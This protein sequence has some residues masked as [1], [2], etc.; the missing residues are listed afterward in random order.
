MLETEQRITP[1]T[2][3]YAVKLHWFWSIIN[4]PTLNISVVKI[5]SKTQQ[6]DYLTKGLPT[7]AFQECR[8]LTQGW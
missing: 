6:A 5:D 8:K 1:R 2:K 3:H 4:D 7:P